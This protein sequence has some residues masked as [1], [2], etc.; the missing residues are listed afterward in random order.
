[1]CKVGRPDLLVCR[2]SKKYLENC[3]TATTMSHYRKVSEK[4]I[5]IK[6]EHSHKCFTL[7]TVT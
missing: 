3:L 5:L 6:F 4:I 1:M 7:K 2:P